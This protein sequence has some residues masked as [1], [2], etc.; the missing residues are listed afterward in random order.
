VSECGLD[1]PDGLVP[2]GGVDEGGADDRPVRLWVQVSRYR[3]DAEDRAR[4]PEGSDPG[5]IPVIDVGRIDSCY[6]G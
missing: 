4:P 3:I 6:W 1:H 5:H 2:I